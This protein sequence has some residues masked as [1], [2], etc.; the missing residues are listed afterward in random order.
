[1]N[2]KR[3]TAPMFKVYG[4]MLDE[5]MLNEY[6]LRQLMIDVKN[7]VIPAA[8]II[9][10]SDMAGNETVI[11]EQGFLVGELEGLSLMSDLFPRIC[12]IGVPDKAI[13]MR[14]VKFSE[15]TV[16]LHEFFNPS[17]CPYETNLLCMYVLFFFLE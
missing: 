11:N 10:V 6:E 9:G 7:G 1:M 14:F 15:S 12:S 4:P 2:I 3:I 16:Y 17:L 5:Y 8:S 13:K